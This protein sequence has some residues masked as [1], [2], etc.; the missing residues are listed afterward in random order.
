MWVSFFF[1]YSSLYD[2]THKNHTKIG[3][4]WEISILFFGKKDYF[5]DNFVWTS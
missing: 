1:V 4:N 5:C 2:Y 3:N